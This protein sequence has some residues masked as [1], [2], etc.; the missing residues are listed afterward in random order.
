MNSVKLKIESLDAWYGAVHVLKNIDLDIYDRAITAVIGP[1]GC[2]KTTL[3]RVINRLHETVPYARVRGHVYLDGVDIYSS[4][5]NPV[6]IRRKI[7]MIFQQPTVFPHLSIYENVAIGLRLN[8]IKDKEFVDNVVK[9]SLK[10]AGLWGEVKERLWDRATEL[11]GGQKQRVAIARAVALEPEVLLMDEPTS[12]LDPSA[13]ARIEALMTSL[14]KEYTIVVVTHNIQFAAR[15]AD[16]IAFLFD[17][18]LI[19]FGRAHEILE[20]PKEKLTERYLLGEVDLE[21]GGYS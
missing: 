11:S 5:V 6:E 4:D 12:A 7:G 19:E 17:G 10:E 3:L 13:T 16:Y 9:R 18:K 20:R 2:G 15:T 8:G 14:K 1:S 21:R